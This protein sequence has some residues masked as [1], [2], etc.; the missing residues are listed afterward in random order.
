MAQHHTPQT[1]S[2]QD[3]YLNYYKTCILNAVLLW[4]GQGI[5]SLCH[6]HIVIFSPSK[7]LSF[8]QRFIQYQF[9][10]IL[11]A[12]N[13]KIIKKSPLVDFRLIKWIW[14]CSPLTYRV[15]MSG[16]ECDCSAKQIAYGDELNY[17]T[18]LGPFF[19]YFHIFI[20]NWGRQL[21]AVFSWNCCWRQ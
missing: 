4:I 18:S 5:C 19:F 20:S 2:A 12:A 3:C 11:A 17:I 9:I 16:W 8:C 13:K 6:M 7:L 21:S 14:L 1:S 10:S 15:F